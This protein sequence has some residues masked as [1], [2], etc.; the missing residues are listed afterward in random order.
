ML[1]HR[2]DIPRFLASWDIAAHPSKDEALG[3]A[4]IEASMAGLPVVVY[5]S[6]AAPEIVQDGST[7]IVVPLSADD[8]SNVAGL[9][10]AFRRLVDD[11]AMR[12]RMGSAGQQRM[13]AMFGSRAR[14]ANEYSSV[15]QNAAV[16]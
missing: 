16:K 5:E 10:G 13:S 1:G 12:Q 14:A 6:G 3:L 11:E 7:G 8:D 15:L 4:V 9:T 2:T